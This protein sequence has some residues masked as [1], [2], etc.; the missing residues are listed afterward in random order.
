MLRYYNYFANN[1]VVSAQH[2]YMG[3][4]LQSNQYVSVN[5]RKS[6]EL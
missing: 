1:F 5:D 2:A 4:N 3:I 6:Y